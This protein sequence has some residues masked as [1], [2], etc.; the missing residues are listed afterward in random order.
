MTQI[1]ADEIAKRAYEIWEVDGCL[2][3]R[4]VDYWLQAEAELVATAA[5]KVTGGQTIE[6]P[7]AEPSALKKP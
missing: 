7:A 2:D 3:G 1:S 4:D 6:A 5:P